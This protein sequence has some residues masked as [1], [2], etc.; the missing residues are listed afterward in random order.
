MSPAKL[1]RSWDVPAIN[2]SKIEKRFNIR[3]LARFSH[4]YLPRLKERELVRQATCRGSDSLHPLQFLPNAI[5]DL[6]GARGADTGAGGAEL[7]RNT[8]PPCSPG[9]PSLGEDTG[10]SPNPARIRYG[11]AHVAYLQARGPSQPGV[12]R[13]DYYV[14]DVTFDGETIVA[15]SRGPECDAARVLLARGVTGSLVILD[16]NTGKHRTTVSIEAAANLT[17][18][19]SRRQPPRFAKWKP[20]AT[21]AEVC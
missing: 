6:D 14:Y 10:N 2:R 17:V 16:A 7:V 21:D 11:E 8:F 4:G 5:N 20:Y 19:E 9:E 13:D 18:S 1:R 3:N 12:P 15:G